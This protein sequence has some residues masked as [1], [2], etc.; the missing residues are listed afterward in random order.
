MLI[1]VDIIYSPFYT[2]DIN[3]SS[4]SK[5]KS[6]VTQFQQSLVI[7]SC[8]WTFLN[9]DWCSCDQN[10]RKKH[11]QETKQKAMHGQENDIHQN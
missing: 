8:F 4:G 5:P 9:V 11:T 3:I 10:D 1:Y 2:S 7:A 6:F